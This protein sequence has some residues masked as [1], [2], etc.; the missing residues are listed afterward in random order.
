MIGNLPAEPIDADVGRQAARD[1]HLRFAVVP[2]EEDVAPVEEGRLSARAALFLRHRPQV[3]DGDVEAAALPVLDVAF[4]GRTVD[5]ERHL[6]DAGVDEA[7][8]LVFVQREPVGA[9]VD[10][11]VREMRLDVL[12]HLDRALVEK[13]FA[14]VEEIDPLQ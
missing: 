5:G 8:R 13:R 3:G 6:V 10:V 12:A 4:L 11:D 9:R 7:A 1:V 14:V 2:D